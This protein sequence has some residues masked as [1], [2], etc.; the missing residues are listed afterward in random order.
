MES[1]CQFHHTQMLSCRMKFLLRWTPRMRILSSWPQRSSR[2][3]MLHYA[4]LYFPPNPTVTCG[5]FMATP[6]MSQTLTALKTSFPRARNG[7]SYLASH[8]RLSFGISFRYLTQWPHARNKT[9]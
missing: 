4:S 3:G 9:R 5:D 8:E 1:H 7:L 2:H 6:R